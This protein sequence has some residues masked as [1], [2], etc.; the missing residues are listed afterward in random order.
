MLKNK[1]LDKESGFLFYGITPPKL[2]TDYERIRTI[3]D[4]QKERLKDV[5]LDAIV[6]YDIQDESSRTSME[7]PFPYIQTISPYEYSQQYLNDIDTPKIIYNSVGKYDSRG[8][9]DWILTNQKSIDYTVFVGSPS[10]NQELSLSLKEAYKIKK[11]VENTMLLGGVTI[12]ERHASKGDEH[13]R[14]FGKIEQGCTFFITQCVYNLDNSKNFLSDYFFTSQDENIAM[15]PIIFTLTPC[16]SLKTLQFM[17]WLGIDIPRWLG[18]EL[19]HS[20][21][22]LEDSIENC[23]YI[24]KELLVF[25]KKK[26]IPIGFNIESV[27]IRKEEIEASIMLVKDIKQIMDRIL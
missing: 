3:S 25:S 21:N 18:N 5:D 13:L 24:A 20:R 7:R 14:V 1:I 4:K 26:S 22:I 15:A 12:P 17:K 23:K 27:A 10:R 16:G 11:N 9:T 8:L 6:L 2:N 19:Q